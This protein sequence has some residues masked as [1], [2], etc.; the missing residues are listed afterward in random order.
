MVGVG[1]RGGGCCGD[2]TGH[3]CNCRY[4]K[5]HIIRHTIFSDFDDARKIQQT[6]LAR[7]NLIYW[8]IRD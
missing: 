8:K 3:E 1:E 7:R 5:S 2:E 4:L 6:C